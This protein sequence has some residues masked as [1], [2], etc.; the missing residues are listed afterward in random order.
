MSLKST[1]SIL[2]V[3]EG[4]YT[5]SNFF[6]IR[7]V[8]IQDLSSQSIQ[9]CFP[10][11]GSISRIQHGLPLHYSISKQNLKVYDNSY[12]KRNT[13]SNILQCH[14]CLCEDFLLWCRFCGG[15]VNRNTNGASTAETCGRHFDAA[16]RVGPSCAVRDPG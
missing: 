3:S 4:C 8:F 13:L 1:Y 12:L 11:I 6:G 7:F 5:K 14:A 15:L 16:L 9:I 10:K 2:H